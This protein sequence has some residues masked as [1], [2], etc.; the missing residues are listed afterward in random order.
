MLARSLAAYLDHVS[1]VIDQRLNKS[2]ADHTS[3][4]VLPLAAAVRSWFEEC[5][6]D[7]TW[8]SLVDACAD[9]FR[10]GEHRRLARWQSAL[11]HWCRR[12][13]LYRDI[14]EGRHPNGTSTAEALEGAA[15]VRED[16]VVRLALLGGVCFSKAVM[17]FGSFQ[18]IRPSAE[19]LGELLCISINRLFYPNAAT[20]IDRLT[21]HWYLRYEATEVRPRLGSI[22]L[23]EGMFGG[24]VRPR[25]SE[26]DPR[27]EEL[28]KVLVLSGHLGQREEYHSN[29]WLGASIPFVIEARD[30]PFR[31]PPP[32]PPIGNLSYEPLFD[33]NGEEEGE[34]PTALIHLNQLETAECESFVRHLEARLR[35]IHTASKE[36]Q[37]FV[38]RGLGYLVKAYFADG[39]E[40]LIWHIVALE[41]FVGEERRVKEGIATRIAALYGQ[42]LETSKAACKDF[43]DL[44]EMR[45]SYVHGRQFKKQTDSSHLWRAREIAVVIA[46]RLVELMERIAQGAGSAGKRQ[47]PRRED[48]LE[49]LYADG[50]RVQHP[51]LA[52]L[53]AS[54]ISG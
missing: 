16:R 20:S 31:P 44:Y 8:H 43:K 30:N 18:I 17:D 46:N 34:R 28:L 11:G 6:R 22:V 54:G 41:A 9:A 32:A 23:T 40:Q 48:L 2:S 14:L 45:C 19:Y 42:D 33:N 35:C 53:L 25:Y 12:A 21:D 10:G 24:P 50:I 36:W 3:L 27:L 13:G 15:R 7:P 47:M 5:E 1:S 37:Q 52:G 29:G 38:D 49:V 51:E 39:I 4:R 26:F